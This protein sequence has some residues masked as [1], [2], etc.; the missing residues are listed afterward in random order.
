MKCLAKDPSGVIR[1]AARSGR[2]PGTVS[3]RPADSGSPGR[4]VGTRLE[5]GSTPPGSGRAGNGGDVRDCRRTGGLLWHESVLRRLNEQLRLEARRPKRMLRTPVISECKS[6]CASG[7]S[8]ASWQVTRFRA[9]HQAVMAKNFGLAHR[10]L[11]AAGPE[12][13]TP[14]N[15]G[16]A[17]SYLRRYVRGGLQV[18]TGHNA[19]VEIVAVDHSGQILASGDA[20]GEVRLWNIA[21][22][23]SQRLSPK[24]VAKVKHLVFSP[25]DR[26]LAS[27]GRDTG[28]IL[29][30]DVAAGRIRG[31]PTNSGPAPVSSLMFVENG[32]R[33]IAVRDE[34]N[35]ELPPIN[36]WDITAATGDF[37]RVSTDER[38][39]VTRGVID[40]R[41]QLL[42]D[43]LDE[44]AL[45]IS[46]APIIGD[47]KNSLRSRRAARCRPHTRR[48]A[49]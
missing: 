23:R 17:W 38:A 35:L 4:R 1:G 41:L 32:N 37:P 47:L 18:F 15:R 30:W 6:K 49:G 13:G 2:R 43:L 36:C 42:A 48:R 10:L 46:S 14:A 34:R 3:R 22:G 7:W 5:V 44:N 25:D 45:L 12:F 11:D 24:H 26:T 31:R 16:F 40:E 28:E 29:V 21:T 20:A 33:L 27:C 9:A 8:G 19:P 39:N